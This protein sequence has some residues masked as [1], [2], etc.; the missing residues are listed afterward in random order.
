MNVRERG[1]R[2]F[3]DWRVGVFPGHTHAGARAG[4]V[5][6]GSGIFLL[7]SKFKHD[8]IS[9]DVFV[10]SLQ[11][12]RWHQLKVSF[13]SYFFCDVLLTCQSAIAEYGLFS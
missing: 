1:K 2:V 3:L 7:S 8:L 9:K 5:R 12:A 6:F 11:D 10:A 13:L 4:R